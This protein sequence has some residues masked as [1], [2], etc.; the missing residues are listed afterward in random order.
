MNRRKQ[1]LILL[2]A[3]VL[4]ALVLSVGFLALTLIAV[5][6]P[7]TFGENGEFFGIAFSILAIITSFI[8]GI[9]LRYYRGRKRFLKSLEDENYYTLGIR[10]TFYN[11]EAFKEKVHSM[12][13]KFTLRNKLRF[14]LAFSPTATSLVGSSNRNRVLQHLNRT[15]ATYVTMNMYSKE[16]TKISKKN[17]VFAFDRNAFLFYLFVDD[18]NDVHTLIAALSKKC[19]E[20]VNDEKNPIRIWVQPFSGICRVEEDISL[21]ASIERAL[22]A[23]TQSEQNIESFSYFKEGFM[24]KDSVVAD[25][26][27]QGIENNEFIPYYQPK[28]S[29][30]EKRFVS[31]EALARWKTPEGI[32]ARIK[33]IDRAGRAGL[34]N[35]IDMAIFEAAIKDVG[36]QLK[37]GRKVIPVS[38]NFSLYEFF[39]NNFLTKVRETLQKNQVPPTLLEIEITET[40]SQVNKFL[41]LQV[42]KKLRD[43]GVRILMDDFGTGF[44]QIENLRQIPFDAI[45]IDKSFTDRILEDEKIRSIVRFLI[46]LIHDN[47]MEAIVEGVE[48][49][50]QVE[51]LRKM[52]VDTIQGFYYSRPLPINEFQILLKESKLDNK[53]K[54]A[55]RWLL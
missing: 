27:A 16:N 36:D 44:S 5:I 31:A 41:S 37:R 54:G 30:T 40:T 10:S 38:V 14:V 25:D 33:F 11:L 39:S 24:S 17:C 2:Y 34:L 35:R 9:L 19:F 48:S 8:F 4:I 28:Y 13:R 51:L 15:I 49:I 50:E 22:I 29:L 23:K 52:K 26:I 55:E 43:M 21:T 6:S 3:N 47:D 32:L 42:I 45:K 18:E 53:G 1:P 20:L 46:Q 7:S 12:E